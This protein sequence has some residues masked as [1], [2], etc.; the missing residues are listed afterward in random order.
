MA[1]AL[2]R[3]VAELAQTNGWR[4]QQ[5]APRMNFA[6]SDAVVK[7]AHFEKVSQLA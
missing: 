7:I 4:I 6:A 3:K 1:H 5:S 2:I